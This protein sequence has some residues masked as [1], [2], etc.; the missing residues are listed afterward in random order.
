VTAAMVRDGKSGEARE[1]ILQRRPQNGKGR[2]FP[3]SGL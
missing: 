1:F 3:I 2:G